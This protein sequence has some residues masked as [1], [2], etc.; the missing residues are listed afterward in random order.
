[1]CVFCMLVRVCFVYVR[2]IECLSVR[3]CL[4]YWYECVLY[5]TLCVF[6]MLV[7]VCYVC[8]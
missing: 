5:I 7:R 6:C 3:E 2:V 4:K 1:M 8:V